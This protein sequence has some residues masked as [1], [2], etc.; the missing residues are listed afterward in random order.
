M[1][2]E[3]DLGDT[4]VA[5]ATAPGRGAIA[6]VRLSGPAAGSIL[7]SL[8][9]GE[10]LPRARMAS[11]R[12]LRDP[13]T[14]QVLDRA[15]V[16]WFPGPASYSGEDLVEI[17]THGGGMASALVS[18][19]CQALGA[20]AAA[21]G[22][23]TR[24]AYLNGKLD[25]VQAEAVQDLVE[26]RSR[27]AHGAALHQLEGGLSR[28]VARLREGLLELEVL[29]AHH[30]DFPD[31]DDPPTPLGEVVAGARRLEAEVRALLR[32]APEGALLREGALVV[33]AGRPNAGKSSLFNALLGEERAIV[34]EEA[35]TTRDAVESTV[36]VKG[37]PFRLVDTAGLRDAPGK[38]ERLGVEVARR[39][40]ERAHLVLFCHAV[41]VPWGGEEGR[42]LEEWGSRPVIVVRTC[43]DRLGE[44]GREDLDMPLP[45]MEGPEREV[46]SVSVRSG[47]GLAALRESLA[48]RVFGGLWEAGDD[49]VVVTRERQRRALSRAAQELAG[50]GGAVEGGV[51]VDVAAGHL[52]EA[53]VALEELVGV[54]EPEAVLE[55]LFASFC[56]GK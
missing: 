36:S 4:I 5:R 41:D 45:G 48:R 32:L 18:E 16:T 34:T 50:F 54:I 25:L 40:L 24:R 12:T 42:F 47:E 31:E 49:E 51:P 8:T 43:V 2:G 23:F 53:G 26:G 46:R 28:R 6:V 52:R 38:V 11:V 30:V 55:R 39:Y 56:I 29:V 20:R 1:T 9:G 21:P 19:A 37:F 27:A 15:L 44:P 17:S 33:L 13:G 10:E 35:G 22:E 3:P 7:R 14:A